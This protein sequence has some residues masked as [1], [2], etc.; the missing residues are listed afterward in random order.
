MNSDV[1]IRVSERKSPTAHRPPLSSVLSALA[2]LYGLTL[3]QYLH[4]KR[5]IVVGALFLLPVALAIFARM[6]AHQVPGIALE[7]LLVFMF[8]PQ[9]ILPLIALLYASGMVQDEIEEQTITYLLIRPLPKWT[10]YCAKLL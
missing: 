10:L 6:T 8:I 9:A 5:W 7:F 1:A 2:T 3:R 4:G